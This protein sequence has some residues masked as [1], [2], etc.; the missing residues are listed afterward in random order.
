MKTFVK[1]RNF[2]SQKKGWHILLLLL[3]IYCFITK[4]FGN[5]SEYLQYNCDKFDPPDFCIS[6]EIS[7]DYTD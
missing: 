7:P 4:R 1:E 5:A 6:S 2:Y 3:M